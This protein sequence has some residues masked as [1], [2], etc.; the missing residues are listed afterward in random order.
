MNFCLLFL[1]GAFQIDLLYNFSITISNGDKMEVNISS[2]E[3]L[4]SIQNHLENNDKI[5]IISLD[6]IVIAYLDF[7]IDRCQ[8]L[9]CNVQI[10]K[11]LLINLN[12]LEHFSDRIQIIDKLKLSIICHFRIY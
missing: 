9:N 8:E 12:I 7:F 3:H 1:L 6:S 5:E 11:Q 4:T 2:I 10:K